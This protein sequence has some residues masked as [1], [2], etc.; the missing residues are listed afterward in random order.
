[1]GAH[2]R[3]HPAFGAIGTFDN[4][5]PQCTTDVGN[6]D[7]Y[8]VGGLTVVATCTFQVPLP[9]FSYVLDQIRSAGKGL[10]DQGMDLLKRR[11]RFP[12]TSKPDQG[13]MMH[14]FSLSVAGW[15]K[16][17]YG[18]AGPRGGGPGRMGKQ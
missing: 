2:L 16:D 6:I 13:A 18:G 4:K 15:E 14:T 12:P 5:R 11:P 9:C 10:Q 1:M 17:G 8:T 7:M 3:L